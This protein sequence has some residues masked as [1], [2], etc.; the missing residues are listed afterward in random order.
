MRLGALMRP[1]RGVLLRILQEVSF[2]HWVPREA[3]YLNSKQIA[4]VMAPAM[5]WALGAQPGVSKALPRPLRRLADHNHDS[6]DCYD[7]VTG[8]AAGGRGINE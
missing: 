2:H 1:L 3:E 4:V 5:M 7:E 6:P 8:C